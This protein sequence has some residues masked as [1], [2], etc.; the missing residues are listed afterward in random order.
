MKIKLNI[1]WVVLASL[2]TSGIYETNLQNDYLLNS[3]VTSFL[4]CHY[5][6]ILNATEFYTCFVSILKV[7]I[8][9]LC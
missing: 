4:D 1:L 9:E 7:C 6:N 5:I 3:V 2:G 8:L